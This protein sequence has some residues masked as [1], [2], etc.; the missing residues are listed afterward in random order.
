MHYEYHTERIKIFSLG[1]VTF[2]IQFG[3]FDL[4]GKE[5]DIRIKG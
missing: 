5:G 2:F 1:M 4:L 3:T